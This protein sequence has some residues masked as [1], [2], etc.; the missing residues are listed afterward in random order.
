MSQDDFC[1]KFNG[2]TNHTNKGKNIY[3]WRF[4]Q[5]HFVC[6]IWQWHH[7]PPPGLSPPAELR[8]Y[9]AEAAAWHDVSAP[10]HRVAP[11]CGEIHFAA[12]QWLVGSYKAPENTRKMRSGSCWRFCWG[13]GV[14]VFVSYLLSGRTFKCFLRWKFPLHMDFAW[15]NTMVKGVLRVKSQAECTWT[16]WSKPRPWHFPANNPWKQTAGTWKWGPPWKRSNIDTNH[17]FLAF[18]MFVFQGVR[19]VFSSFLILISG[20]PKELVSLILQIDSSRLQLNRKWDLVCGFFSMYNNVETTCR[21]WMGFWIN[22]HCRAT[23]L[24]RDRTQRRKK[25]HFLEFPNRKTPQSKM[26]TPRS[27]SNLLIFKNAP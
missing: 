8:G 15:K 16:Q 17:Q 23:L 22:S 14:V 11:R 10:N 13:V 19:M 20:E 9:R 5:K 7:G 24:K 27:K 21:F 18:K 1:V 26:L 2:V 12:G 3:P 6:Q 4:V 25:R